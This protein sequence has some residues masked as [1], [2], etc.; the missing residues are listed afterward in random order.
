MSAAAELPGLSR[1]E[2]VAAKARARAE[3]IMAKEAAPSQERIGGT[4]TI[5]KHLPSSSKIE[6]ARMIDAEIEK[7]IAQRV[8]H[9]AGL[10]VDMRRADAKK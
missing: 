7:L 5:T 3:A 8:P 6:A 2:A 4:I 9:I 1:I 10:K